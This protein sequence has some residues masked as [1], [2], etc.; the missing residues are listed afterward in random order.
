MTATSHRATRPRRFWPIFLLVASLL[1][2]G[3][4]LYEWFN[5]LAP[6]AVDFSATT[7]DGKQWVLAEHRGKKPLVLNF[8][9]T[10]CG[11]CKMELPH[12]VALQ[13]K[14]G[15]DGVEVVLVTDEPADLL[16]QFPE[17]TETPLTF[18]TDAEAVK[19]S[20]GVSAIPHTFVFNREGKLVKDFPGY[21]EEVPGQIED[22][23]K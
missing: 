18:I 2:G 15:P 21:S 14:Y 4:L 11:P 10:W 20:Y 3:A 17:F 5:S 13:K 1:L 8:F 19:T 22:L 6:K 23:I 9:A 7:L 16:K 12:L